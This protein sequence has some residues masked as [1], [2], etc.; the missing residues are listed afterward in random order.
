M[1]NLTDSYNRTHSYLRISV[2]DRCNLRCAY[3]MP[4]DG[5][6]WKKTEELLSFEEI[7]RLSRVFVS[8]GVNKIRITGGEPFMR[9]DLVQLMLQ[10]VGLS[11]LKTLA[12]T[13]NGTLLK[14]RLPL[15]KQIGLHA[16]NISLDTLRR[17]RFFQISRRDDFVTVYDAIQTALKLDFPSLKINVVVIGG[18]NE[19]EVLDFADFAFSNRCNVRFIEFMPF[20]NNDWKPQSVV[21]YVD[22]KAKI[23]T[24]YQLMPIESDRSSVAK[25]FFIYGGLGQI[26]FVS[27]MTESFCGTC[28]RLRLTAEGSLKTCLFAPAEV[29]LRDSIRKGVDDNELRRI[30]VSTLALKPEAHPPANQILTEE[31]MAMIEIGG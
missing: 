8:L 23:Q 20:K 15:L 3:C 4:H 11:G 5:I 12:M 7:L 17:E 26:S 29:S 24:K 30:I 21:S 14:D 6:V 16:L 2:T 19:D 9:P 31:N 13:T 25:D 27:S 1:N 22:M 18:F 10:L 28:N